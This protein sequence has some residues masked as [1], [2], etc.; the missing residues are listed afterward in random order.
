MVRYTGGTWRVGGLLALRYVSCEMSRGPATALL[1]EA[2]ICTLAVASFK[3]P[4]PMAPTSPMPPPDLPTKQLPSTSKVPNPQIPHPP[5]S[6]A[7]GDAYLK[8]SLQFEG[9][10]VDN[11]NSYSSGFG[12][13]AEPYT[14][15]TPLTA[16]D[17]YVVLASDGLFAEELRGGGGGLDNET[18]AELCSSAGGASC[19]QLAKTLSLTAQEVGSTDDV[20]VVV[21]RLGA[22]K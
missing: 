16:G 8:G 20:T 2:W 18:V 19:E 12:L 5:R 6:R 4:A 15:V 17:T 1:M 7:F 11:S 22:S 14:T 13:I 21:L 10:A 3:P 9:L